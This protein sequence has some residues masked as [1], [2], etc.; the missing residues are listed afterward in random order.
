MPWTTILRS[1]RFR[2]P[3][4]VCG[5]TNTSRISKS[6]HIVHT[7]LLFNIICHVNRCLGVLD[8]L[9][10]SCETT[11]GIIK[12]WQFAQLKLHAWRVKTRCC[13]PHIAQKLFWR[14][15]PTE[16]INNE[17]FGKPKVV[18]LVEWVEVK[19]RL[20]FVTI[21]REWVGKLL[22]VSFCDAQPFVFIYGISWFLLFPEILIVPL[23]WMTHISNRIAD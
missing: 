14:A 18:I 20:N 12:I 21:Y 1:L 3:F 19:L 5:L 6:T 22:E 23:N 13:W 17:V 15:Y 7:V 10:T 11:N 2:K 9:Q 4:C 16:T 8:M